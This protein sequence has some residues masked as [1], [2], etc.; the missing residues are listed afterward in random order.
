MTARLAK[1]RQARDV[2][3]A[4][5]RSCRRT[6]DLQNSTPHVL[7]EG[8]LRGL[9]SVITPSQTRQVLYQATPR[10]RPSQYGLR[11][12]VFSTLPMLDRGRASRNSTLRGHL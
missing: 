8:A 10:A 2:V 1:P 9:G 3:Y 4:R 11:N 6:R 5:P 7:A 12:S